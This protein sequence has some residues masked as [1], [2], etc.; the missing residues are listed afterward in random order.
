MH[1]QLPPQPPPLSSAP[2][3][4][5]YAGADL[6]WV[7]EDLNPYLA[8]SSLVEGKSGEKK[9]ESSKNREIVLSL[10]L[11]L[12]AYVRMQRL[13]GKLHR[14]AITDSQSGMPPANISHQLCSYHPP[15]AFACPG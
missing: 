7:L 5:P 9:R 4:A 8:R 15:A 13:P 11:F 1:L 2:A 14:D 10:I 12:F 6:A 3:K